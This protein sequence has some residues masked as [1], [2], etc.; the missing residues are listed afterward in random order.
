[1][2]TSNPT[3]NEGIIDNYRYSATGRVMT[4]QGTVNKVAVLVLLAFLAATYT[5]SKVGFSEDGGLS[6]PSWSIIGSIGAFVMAL[7]ISFKK[8]WAPMLSPVYAVLEGL[9]LGCLS[10]VL[11]LKYPGIVLRAITLTFAV[12]FAVLFMYKTGIIRVT[13]SFVRIVLAATMGICLAY[14]VAFILSLFGVDASFMYGGGTVGIVLSLVVVG[15]AAMNL[16]LDFHFI[17]QGAEAGLPAHFEWYSAFGLMVTLVWLYV[18]ILRLLS[19]LS[20]R[21]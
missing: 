7:I 2:K 10:G 13:Q 9:F 14:F 6:V 16:I 3:L 11:E 20:S 8:E 19:K 21:D 12:M 17:E 4:V 5:W 15:V 1:M 18:E